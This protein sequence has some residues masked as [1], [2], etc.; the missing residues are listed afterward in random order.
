MNCPKCKTAA[1]APTQVQAV[2]VDQ[3]PRCHGIWFDEQELGRLLAAD[4]KDLKP[5]AR[6]TNDPGTDA[7]T[8]GCP[9]DGKE[10]LRVRSAKDR[11]VV[12]DICP[13]CRGIWLDGGEF[14]RL[15]AKG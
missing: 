9:R 15:L 11:Q 12:V 10:L 4:R 5:L 8:G 3:C 6:S 7:V 2:Q 13:R 14:R 1:L